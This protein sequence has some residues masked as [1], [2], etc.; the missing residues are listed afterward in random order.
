RN[1]WCWSCGAGTGGARAGGTGT[2]DVGAGGA[3]AVGAEAG[4]AGVGG[5]GPAAP[6]ITGC[7][8]ITFIK[9]YPHPFKGTVGA[10]GLCQWFEKLEFVFRISDCKERDKVKFATAT[11]QGRALAWWNGRIAS[12]GIDAANGTP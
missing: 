9:Y 5:A 4:G 2:D 12:M 10:V 11:L 6:K 7:T 8:Y 3:E 1:R